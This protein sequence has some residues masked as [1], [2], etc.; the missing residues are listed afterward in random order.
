[1]ELAWWV[2]GVGVGRGRGFV[3]HLVAR[4]Q[5]RLFR[6]RRTSEKGQQRRGVMKRWRDTLLASEA[7]RAVTAM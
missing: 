1:M 5:E 2:G 4:V 6:M 7:G 3:M